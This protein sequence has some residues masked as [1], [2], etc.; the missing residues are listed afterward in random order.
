MD[1]LKLLG[2]ID[3]NKIAADVMSK[4]KIQP[5]DLYFVVDQQPSTGKYEFL[6]MTYTHEAARQLVG[7]QRD[8]Q[9]V[10]ILKMEMGNAVRIMKEMGLVQDVKV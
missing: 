3:L 8:G 9:Q 4:M 2:N 1:L 10:K 5:F 6:G 7:Q